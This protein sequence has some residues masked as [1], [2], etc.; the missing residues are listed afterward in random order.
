MATKSKANSAIRDAARLKGVYLWQIALQLGVS[1]PTLIRWLRAQLT[2]ER[3]KA[4]LIAI[5]HIA[6]EAQNG[7]N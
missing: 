6:K 5:D 7:S 4:I 3:E 1:E 2:E